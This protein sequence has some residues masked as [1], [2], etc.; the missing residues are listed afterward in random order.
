MF[1]RTKSFFLSSAGLAK[2]FLVISVIKLFHV[3][4]ATKV[5]TVGQTNQSVV[6]QQR[7][8]ERLL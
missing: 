1:S 3:G 7:L 5:V 8:A 6:G 4:D 2:Q